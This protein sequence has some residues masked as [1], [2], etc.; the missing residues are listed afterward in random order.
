MA[1]STSSPHKTGEDNFRSRKKKIFFSARLSCGGGRGRALRSPVQARAWPAPPVPSRPTT[2]GNRRLPRV[3]P[4]RARQELGVR[5][6]AAPTGEAPPEGPMSGPRPNPRSYHRPKPEKEAVPPHLRLK[7]AA[8]ER[9]LRST[10]EQFNSDTKPSSQTAASSSRSSVKTPDCAEPVCS[11]WMI[12]PAGQP[13]ASLLL[14]WVA[15]D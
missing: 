11:Y 2:A 5:S 13:I 15:R 8:G 10:R 1:R 14:P 4:A 9:G 3:P 7:D 12:D 6:P